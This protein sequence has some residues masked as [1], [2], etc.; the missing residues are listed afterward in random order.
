MSNVATVRSSTRHRLRCTSVLVAL[1]AAACAGGDGGDRAG[2]EAGGLAAKQELVVGAGEDSYITKGDESNVGQYPMNANIFET[3]VRMT[4]DYEIVP[5]LATEWEFE[6]PNT[7]RFHLRDDV[8]FHDGTRFTADAVKYT[9]D[10]IARTGGGTPGFE[11]GGTKVVD[12]HTVEITPKFENR[13]FVEQV[14]HPNYSIIAP[15]SDPGKEPI[16][17]GPFKFVSYERQEQ[18]VVERN[19]EYWDEAPTLDRITFRFIPE[20]NARR[21]ALEAGEVDMIVDVP[22]EAVADLEGKG[23]NIEKSDVGAYEAMYAKFTTAGGYD[24]ILQDRAVRQAVSYAIDREALVEGVFEGLAAPEQTM[25]PS[26][27]LGDA[28]AQVEGYDYD[29]EQAAQILD[30]AGWQ[31]GSGGMREKGGERLKLLLIDGFPSAQAHGSVPEFIQSQLEEVGIDVEIVRTPDAPAYEERLNSAEG[32]LWLEQGSQ[33][34]AN[35]AFL[36]A[37]LFWTEGLFGNIGYQPH[38]APGG[39][40]DDVIVEA[41]ATPDNDEVKRLVGEAMHLLIDEEAVVIPLAGIFRIHAMAE[42]VQNFEAHPSG[43]QI[44]YDDVTIVE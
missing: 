28:A 39:E 26:R 43:L 41:L 8:E 34:D 18:I 17:T 4:P 10:R 32:D 16:G 3:L 37:L 42:E 12:D 22:R 2:E 5:A 14:V 21:L 19:D 7:W 27:L 36:P 15:D 30:D 11:K 13:R 9:F 38:F 29:P 6:A 25:V 24:T 1:V 31:E 20:A 35:P 40:F 44:R 23:F 33:N